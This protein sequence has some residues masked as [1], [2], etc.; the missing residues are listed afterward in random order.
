MGVA[1]RGRRLGL[2]GGD[3]NAGRRAALA[4]A[5][6][7]EQSE[8]YPFIFI[9]KRG[10]TLCSTELRIQRGCHWVMSLHFSAPKTDSER[11]CRVAGGISEWHEQSEVFPFMGTRTQGWGLL[12]G[13]LLFQLTMDYQ[14]TCLRSPPPL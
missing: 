7:H 4:R 12:E 8:D 1:G 13:L 10:E 9:E 3:A 14:L 6:R 5:V 11:Q 2:R